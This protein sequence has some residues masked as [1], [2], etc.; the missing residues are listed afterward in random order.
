MEEGADVASFQLAGKRTMVVPVALV[1][2]SF[3]VAIGKAMQVV[4]V[5]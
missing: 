1:E 2:V 5:V 4:G 3:L